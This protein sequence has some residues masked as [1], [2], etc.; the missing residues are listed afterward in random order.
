MAERALTAEVLAA[1]ASGKVRPVLFFEGEFDAGGSPA[2]SRLFTGVGTFEWDGKT[3]VG[4]GDLLTMSPIRESTSL[5]AIGFSV[6]LSGLPSDNLSIALQ[7]M[8]KN[9]PGKL[10][11][12]FLEEWLFLADEDGIPILDE[13][14]EGIILPP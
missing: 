9:K 2:H 11:L 3:W 6:K 5:E 13:N 7:S 4:G 1:I 10:W 8:M 12:G 14:N